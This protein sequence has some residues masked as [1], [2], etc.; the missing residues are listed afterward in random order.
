MEYRLR[1]E[2]AD[3]GQQEA[4]RRPALAAVEVAAPLGHFFD[5]RDEK[6]RLHFFNFRAERAQALRRGR[7]IGGNA[8]ADDLGLLLAERRADQQ[9][10]RLRFGCRD[11]HTSRARAGYDGSLHRM[12]PSC[13]QSRRASTG[14][15]SMRT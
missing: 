14:I 4:Q 8:V 10:V 6:A 9:P 15:V 7:D 2:R 3:D 11:V 1:A 13:I 12:P 5:R